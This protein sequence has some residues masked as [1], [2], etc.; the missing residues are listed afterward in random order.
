MNRRGT[1]VYNLRFPDQYYMAETGLSQNVFRD[2]D[3]AAGRYVESDPIGLK[4]GSYS[5]YTYVAGNPISRTD[6]SGLCDGNWHVVGE[7]ILTFT[8]V[9][10]K[11]RKLDDKEFVG[12][13]CKC[14]WLCEPCRGSVAYGDVHSL[15]S[16]LGD[17]LIIN[18]GSSS[19][20]RCLC[21]K[22]KERETG[23]HACYIDSKF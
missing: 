14:F 11:G 6:R 13:Q 3:P 18:T 1:F 22:P 16:T 2:F 23:C 12:P 21:P 8:T 4:G 5:T 7:A 15:P 9:E 20:Y 19:D 17:T 10:S